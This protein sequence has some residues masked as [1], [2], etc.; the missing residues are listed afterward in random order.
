MNRRSKRLV[1][2]TLVLSGVATLCA[3]VFPTRADDDDGRPADA[4]SATEKVVIERAPVVVVDAKT[5]QV[6]MQLHP[7]KEV[8][9]TAPVDGVVST[10]HVKT[11]DQLNAQT[12]VA[13]LDGTEQQLLLDKAKAEFRVAQIEVDVAKASNNG[14]QIKAAE[15]RLDA[16]KA[17]MD[18][19]QYR[20]DRNQIRVPWDAKIFR[21]KVVPGQPVRIGDPL[22]IVADASRFQVEIPVDRKTAKPGGD[23][24]IRIEDK[25]VQAKV[26]HVIRLSERFEPLREVVDSI[27]SAVVEIDNSKGEYAAGQTVYAPIIPRQPVTEV[28][29]ASVANGDEGTRKVQVVRGNMV[30]DVP[31]NLLGQVGLDRVH[32]AGAFAHGDELILSS[33]KP[34]IDGTP[35]RPVAMFAAEKSQTGRGTLGTGQSAKPKRSFGF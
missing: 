2:G 1:F 14:A 35:V 26:K 33:S 10:I 29:T 21:I 23:V 20:L 12:E 3:A 15:A 34:L 18:L 4:E 30:R 32:V 11:G 17:G 8:V 19:A 24:E 22:M 27:A 31:V 13:R 28:P 25:T 5:Y 16:A 7:V 6:P 9:L